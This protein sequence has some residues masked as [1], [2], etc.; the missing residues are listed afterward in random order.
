MS[1]ANCTWDVRAGADGYNVYLLSSSVFVKVNRSLIT[2]NSYKL[3]N[4]SPGSYSAYVT[5]VSGSNETSPSNIDNFVIGFDSK[6]TPK[7][8]QSNITDEANGNISFSWNLVPG[9]SQ[10]NFYL[11]SVGGSW[12]KQ[13]INPIYLN[14][15]SL[16]GLTPDDYEW[17][18][19]SVYNGDEVD[20]DVSSFT[21]KL[22]EDPVI[23]SFTANGKN[24]LVTLEWDID[25]TTGTL[26]AVEYEIDNS[27]TWIALSTTLIGSEDVTGLT[28]GVE[29]SFK[30]RATTNDGQVISGAV[31]ATP[32]DSVE[33]T[34]SSTGRLGTKQTHS[35]LANGTY[36]ITAF[37]AEGGVSGNAAGVAGKGAKIQGDFSLN[38]GDELELLVGQKGEDSLVNP[39]GG[40][41]TVVIKKNLKDWLQFN[42][43]TTK[44][45]L[46]SWDDYGFVDELT[47]ECLAWLDP[48]QTRHCFANAGS[49]F[50]DGFTWYIRDDDTSAGRVY[51]NSSSILDFKAPHE[52]IENLYSAVHHF[53]VTISATEVKFYVDGELIE[54]A[55]ASGINLTGADV[56][57]IGNYASGGDVKG[58]IKNYGIWTVERTQAQL[59]DS[60]ENG[61]VGNETGLHAYYPLDEGSGS[62]AIN[63]VSGGVDGTINNGSWSN[64]FL[65]YLTD[66]LIIA[67]GG[68]AAGPGDTATNNSVADGQTTEAGS[69]AFGERSQGVGGNNGQG[70]GNSENGGPSAGAGFLSSD[71]NPDPYP[72]I[73]AES[74]GEGFAGADS[75]NGDGGYGGGGG[76]GNSGGYGTAGGGGGYSGGGSGY[77][78]SVA[79]E[80]F[81]GG[82]GSK[83]NGTNQSNTAGDNTGHGKII[84]E[85]L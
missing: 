47:I 11:R 21:I 18:V 3:T 81:G 56:L 79:A 12:V 61:L 1:V 42:G 26:S 77:A 32:S 36:R 20:S 65:P 49:N 52:R 15:Y 14:S 23:N 25:E 4:L 58:Y 70:G 53:A 74:Y 43:S 72:T 22:T 13:N 27:G 83:N 85:P 9:I 75:A 30:L 82:G 51:E 40:G 7:N 34:N 8:L 73:L 35:I 28:N 69:D 6:Y 80:V 38:S 66:I 44:I 54:S 50:N 46:E 19:S 2:S 60:M 62:T 67:G 45:D 55:P 17:K 10:F 41:A 16:T 24:T 37:G 48:S 84:I 59:R 64:T 33:Y 63:A 68:G 71:D 78:S 31:T 57:T 29:Y 39:G 76:G 5:A